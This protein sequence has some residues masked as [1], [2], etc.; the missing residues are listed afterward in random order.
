MLHSLPSV[1]VRQV[2]RNF[3][4]AARGYDAVAVLQREVA[5]RMLERLDYVR[6]EPA[7]VLDL[8][9]GTGSSLAA[10]SERYPGAQVIGADFCPQMLFAGQ[11][12]GRRLKWLL[13]FLRR[14]RA[15]L[16]AADAGGLPLPGDALGLLWSNLMLQWTPEPLGVLREMHR[17]LD[18]GGLLM[19]STLGPQ[20]LKELRACFGDA[21]AH[22]Q[23]FIDMHDYGDMLVE[24]GFADPVIDME[25]LTMTYAELP[26]LFDD[27]R[28]NGAGCAIPG[29]PRG[30]MGRRAWQAMGA[31]YERLRADGRLPASF[32]IVYGHAWKAPARKVA[33]GRD[34]IRFERL[35]R[36]P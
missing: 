2:R 33:D 26:A 11:A 31:A 1:D 21:G 25:T 34:I 9:C 4:R 16:L 36:A 12:Q 10:L 23:P 8:G 29:R 30:L 3:A 32:E 6:I 5:R 13:P 18:V 28:R 20:T 19:F 24:C 15:S 14:R 17:V 35:P 7:R 27:L 22:V